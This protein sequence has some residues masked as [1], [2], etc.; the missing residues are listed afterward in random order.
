M[1]VPREIPGETAGFRDNTTEREVWHMADIR[2]TV[3]MV[4]ELAG[5]DGLFPVEFPGGGKGIHITAGPEP[6]R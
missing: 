3:D 6:Y 4:L 5:S 2:F 1:S